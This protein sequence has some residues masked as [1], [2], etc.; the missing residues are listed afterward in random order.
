MQVGADSRREL[1]RQLALGALSLTI[2]AVVGASGYHVL[3]HGSWSYADCLYMTI[4]TLSTVGYGEVLPGMDHLPGARVWTILLIVLGSGSLLFFISTLTAFIV[5]GDIQGVLRRRRMQ[6]QIDQLKDHIIV[7]GVGATGIHVVGELHMTQVPFVVID[8]DGERLRAISEDE[9]PGMLFVHGDATADQVLQQAGIARAKGLAATL[10]EDKDNVFVSITARALNGN[11]RIV[12]KMTEDNAETKLKRA[13]A[14]STVSPS[15]IGGMRIVSELVR[16]SVVQ[17]LDTMLRDRAQALRVEEVSI[18][19]KSSLVG[20]RLRDTTIRNQTKVLVLAAHLPDG[21]YTYNPGP[22]F[23]IEPG[24][25]LVVLCQ[26]EDLR[27]L[28]DGIEQGTIGRVSSS[29]RP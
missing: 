8:M 4:I 26:A 6:K 19:E 25:T 9:L 3:G 18:P 12:A 24:M 23:L 17:F 7:V 29:I 15:Q 27:K 16:P 2:V 11:L 14:N 5:E 28:R 1:I 22:D 13:G 21:T 10:P 20:A